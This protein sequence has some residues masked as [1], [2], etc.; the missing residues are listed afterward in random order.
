MEIKF[1]IIKIPYMK[2]HILYENV[3]KEMKLI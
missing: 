3:I 1:I 2:I